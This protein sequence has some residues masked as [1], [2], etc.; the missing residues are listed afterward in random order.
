MTDLQK[1]LN[2][3]VVEIETI[4]SQMDAGKYPPKKTLLKYFSLKRKREKLWDKI[5]GLYLVDYYLD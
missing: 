4:E 2:Q 1:Q 3:V 5:N